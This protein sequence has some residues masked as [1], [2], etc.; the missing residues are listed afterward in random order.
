MSSAA[1]DMAR[2]AQAVSRPH[3]ALSSTEDFFHQT[4]AVVT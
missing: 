4:P 1:R 3:D 2:M